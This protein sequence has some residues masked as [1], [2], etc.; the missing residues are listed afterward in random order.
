MSCKICGS[1]DVF[2]FMKGIYDCN[3]T[4]VMECKNCEVRFLD[5]IMDLDEEANY[6]KN[7]YRSQEER[8]V[9]KS[10]L[11]D[12]QNGSYEFHK[13][14]ID[15]YSK[16]FTSTSKALEIGAGTGGMLRLLHD[17]LQVK[18]ISA[19]EK[20]ESNISF[21]KDHFDSVSLYYD[22][23][24]IKHKKYDV[25][26]SHALF[27]HLREPK[28]FLLEMKSMLNPDGYLIM[29]MPNKR[30]PLIDILEID[31]F[32]KFT[33]QKQ[34]YFTYNE[35]SLSVL[36]E[37]ASL[38]IDNFYY[39]QRY[40]LDNHMSWLIN[41]RPKDFSSFGKLFS[42]ETKNSY[43]RDLIKNKTTDMLGVVLSK[44]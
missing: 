27:E 6:Y 31:E 28:D 20:S 14:H 40:S 29:E 19:V 9:V 8:Y 16:Y 4:E 35:R 17:D 36:A 10:T 30:E 15:H 43:R 44:D 13:S 21:L 41:K 22:I 34:H 12:I 11:N 5:P 2:Q 1:Q 32:K 37:A 42:E 39:C 24:E 33:Y 23:S 18:N 7:Y 3:K 25:I 26:I 38:N